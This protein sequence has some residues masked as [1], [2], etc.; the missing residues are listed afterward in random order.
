[1]KSPP[2]VIWRFLD[3]N[4]G[5]EKQSQ[6]C[7]EALA[8]PCQLEKGQ[9]EKGQLAG[10]ELACLDIPIKAGAGHYLLGHLLGRGLFPQ[11]QRPDFIIGV[12]HRTHL[13]MLL[14]KRQLG[15]PVVV[16]MSPSLPRHWFDVIIA[17]Q[18]DYL[19]KTLPAN[20]ITT[21]TAPAPRVD[22]C[23]D[24]GQGLILL[25]GASKHFHWDEQRLLADIRQVV[26][27]C[28]PSVQWQVSTSRRTPSSTLEALRR[29]CADLP[30]L[31]VFDYRDLDAQWLATTLKT[32]GKIWV[33]SDSASMLA[34][35]LNTRAE[36]GL[37]AL[38]PK[39]RRNKFSQIH[40]Q[41]IELGVLK[42]HQFVLDREQQDARAAIAIEP[43]MKKVLKK[44]GLS[45]EY[46]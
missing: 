6:A 4:V 33:T 35:A 13:P 1:M 28:A 43:V 14:A 38:A 5:H 44:L 12:G 45:G 31:Q 8:S 24:P 42:S 37:V 29:S 25:G 9:L 3:G 18:H 46:L 20:V 16:V 7:I 39:G 23:P 27:A 10:R 22:S 40:R 26:E 34:E 17:P 2:L 21:M 30:Q 36:V 41:L 11:A 32:A 15:C 19:G